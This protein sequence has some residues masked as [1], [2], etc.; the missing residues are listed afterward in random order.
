MAVPDGGEGDSGT[1]DGVERED[2][3]VKEIPPTKLVRSFFRGLLKQW[4]MDLNARPD[5]V[6]RTVQGKL[7]T[8][9][10]KQAKDYMRPLFKL[11]KQKVG[12]RFAFLLCER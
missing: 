5:H 9:T 7:E 11:C 1:G 4:E 8:K 6:K 10:Q 12:V 3:P 2:K